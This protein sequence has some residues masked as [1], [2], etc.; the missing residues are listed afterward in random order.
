MIYRDGKKNP[1]AGFLVRTSDQTTFSL[2]L[3]SHEI[4]HKSAAQFVALSKYITFCVN[5]NVSFASPPFFFLEKPTKEH[6]KPSRLISPDDNNHQSNWYY[7]NRL[8]IVASN[9]QNQIEGSSPLNP[10]PVAS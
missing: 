4:S 7:I 6:V 10:G 5:A 3:K 8:K 9:Y 2:G 1:Q